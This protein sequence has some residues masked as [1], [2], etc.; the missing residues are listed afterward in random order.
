MNMLMRMFM[1]LMYIYL[2][3]QTPVAMADDKDL[4]E[5]L[6]ELKR[7]GKKRLKVSW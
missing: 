2:V 1:I 6:K 5:V 4:K 7:G 3:D